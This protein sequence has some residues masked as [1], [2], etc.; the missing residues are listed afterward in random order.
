MLGPSA[1]SV[2]HDE[3][4]AQVRP[5]AGPLAAHRLPAGQARIDPVV[6]QAN[7]ERRQRKT[8]FSELFGRGVL[9]FDIGATMACPPSAPPTPTYGA[10][11]M[12]GGS[13][14][15]CKTYLAL[16]TANRSQE[17][18]CGL[19]TFPC[20]WRWL[21]CGLPEPTC[22]FCRYFPVVCAQREVS[23]S[24]CVTK[25]TVLLQTIGSKR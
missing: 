20:G 12:R 19:R 3:Q 10:M 6:R 5:L 4:T 18:T 2:N 22:G 15:S 21:T 17:R 9:V 11:C 8:F 25:N 7:A 1:G 16:C 13:A 23:L 14:I 24:G